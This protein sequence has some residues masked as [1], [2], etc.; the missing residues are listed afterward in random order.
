MLSQALRLRQLLKVGS[1]GQ[2]ILDNGDDLLDKII[3]GGVN[4]FL[5]FN[6]YV[7]IILE[8]GKLILAGG[9]IISVGGK[10]ILVGEVGK[11]F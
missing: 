10:I 5:N 2:E 1:A 3:L 7:K 4:F 11:L 9:K 8:C 6:Y